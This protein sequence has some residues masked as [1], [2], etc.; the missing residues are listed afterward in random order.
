MYTTLTKTELNE[1]LNAT[2]APDSMIYVSIN[3][4]LGTL[5][6]SLTK[7]VATTNYKILA[8]LGRHV[9]SSFIASTKTTCVEYRNIDTFS[10]GGKQ[11]GWGAEVMTDGRD[12]VL[13][14]DW[15][16]AALILALPI[17]EK[18]TLLKLVRRLSGGRAKKYKTIS[19]AAAARGVNAKRARQGMYG[20]ASGDVEVWSDDEGDFVFASEGWRR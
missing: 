19:A 13:K 6:L 10:P 14:S 1:L 4:R 18:E 2:S 16:D 12:E 11:Y 3:A 20:R 5:S 7:V 15:N 9:Y 8:R 17:E